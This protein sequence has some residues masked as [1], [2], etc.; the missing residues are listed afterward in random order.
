[1]KENSMNLLGEVV[2]REREMLAMS[3][4]DLS[5]VT[6][7]SST[8]IERIEEKLILKPYPEF[9]NILSDALGVNLQIYLQNDLLGQE[10]V[11]QIEKEPHVKQ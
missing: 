4:N 8:Y 7:I 9:I 11:F 2:K 6:G 3:I 1:M 5:S 10:N